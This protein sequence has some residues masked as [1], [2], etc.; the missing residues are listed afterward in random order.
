MNLEYPIKVNYEWTDDYNTAYTW[1][2]QLPEL[3]AADFEVASKYTKRDKELFKYRLDHR[4]LSDEEYRVNLQA[5]VSDGLSYPSL[6]E[7]THL[8]VGWT[9]RDSKVIVCNNANIRNLVFR[10]LTETT[11]TQ[12]WHNASFDFKHIFYNTGKLP[13]NYID[14]QLLAKCILNDADSFKDRTGL[15]DLMA[16]AYG[17]W[18]ISKENFTLEE[19]YDENMIRYAA[20]DSP[21]TYRLYQDILKD[22]NGWK[23]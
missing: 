9:D 23:I 20:T 5:L 19:M 11:S 3:F 22:L 6:T 4:K 13:K 21:A 8:S 2:Q 16:Y 14:T 12:I 1:L 15:K 10:F 18:A 17:D 7:V